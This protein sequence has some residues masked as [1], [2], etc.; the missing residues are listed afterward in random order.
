[1]RQVSLEST[2]KKSFN[3]F[4]GYCI[5]Y[6]R[7]SGLYFVINEMPSVYFLQVAEFGLEIV[8]FQVGVGQCHADATF[9]KACGVYMDVAQQVGDG[10]KDIPVTFQL[11]DDKL[12]G[13]VVVGGL[14]VVEPD[15]EVDGQSFG[16][17]LIDKCDTVELVADNGIQVV[18]VLPGFALHQFVNAFCGAE[19]VL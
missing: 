10:R 5:S 1:M 2:A 18:E 8:L 11:N 7:I 13:V 6:V 3:V 16:F 17:F 9:R 19:I 4:I 15:V 12:V 14:K